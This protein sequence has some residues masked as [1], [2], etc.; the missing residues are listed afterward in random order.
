MPEPGCVNTGFSELASLLSLTILVADTDQL[1]Y[2]S[3]NFQSAFLD[4]LLGLNHQ[5][6]SFQQQVFLHC[7]LL[8]AFYAP[9]MYQ[10]VLPQCLGWGLFR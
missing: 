1:D 8:K 10:K 7:D 4:V 6:R 9:C 3:W 2:H 5:G